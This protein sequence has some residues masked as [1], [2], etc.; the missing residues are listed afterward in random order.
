[1]ALIPALVRSLLIFVA[2]ILLLMAF[3]AEPRFGMAGRSWRG[4]YVLITLFASVM[5]HIVADAGASR[6]DSTGRGL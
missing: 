6:I 1:M 5:T 3:M 2:P 4:F